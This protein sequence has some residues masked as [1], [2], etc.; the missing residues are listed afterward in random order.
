[1]EAERTGDVLLGSTHENR[2]GPFI[3]GQPSE[4]NPLFCR[5]MIWGDFVY[6]TAEGFREGSVSAQAERERAGRGGGHNRVRSLWDEFL[7]CLLSASPCSVSQSLLRLCSSVQEPFL[8]VMS[9]TAIS[10]LLPR[11]RSPFRITWWTA[12][13]WGTLRYSYIGTGT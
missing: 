11:P 4:R 1:M 3:N 6:T 12:V 2:F 13:K 5:H 8:K 9:S 10:P 7:S